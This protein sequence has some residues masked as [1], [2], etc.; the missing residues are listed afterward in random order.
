M[1]ISYPLVI[2]W[3]K[4]N[5][6]VLVASEVICLV[7]ASIYLALAPRIYEANFSVRLPKMQVASAADPTKLDWKLML[8]GLEFMRGMQNP[9]TFSNAFIQEC[10]GEDSN[11]NRRKFVNATRISLLNHSDVLH[12]SLR[13]E[14]RENAI[15]C[16]KLLEVR[17]LD[18]LNGVYEIQQQKNLESSNK[19]GS[20]EKASIS[21]SLR[22]SDNYIQPQIGKIIYAAM[23]IGAFLA[24]FAASLRAKYRA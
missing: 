7:L 19:T 9:M 20:N 2:A 11:E 17:V 13:V 15:R 6:K 16:A 10:M 1:K 12:F 23:I 22:I 8:S 21:D 5:W 18:D 24:I 4:R 3:L 14:G